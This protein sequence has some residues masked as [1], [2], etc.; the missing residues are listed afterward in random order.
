MSPCR[1]RFL[2]AWFGLAA[3]SGCA[4]TL[5][6][7][8]AGDPWQTTDA[9]RWS[10]A[11]TTGAGSLYDVD[12]KVGVVDSNFGAPASIGGDIEGKL[13]LG[14][15]AEVFA[16]KDWMVFLGTEYRLYDPKLDDE[17]V[18]F[19]T[20]Q[21]FELFLGTRWY[22]P[23]RFLANRRLRVFLQ[24]K[25]AWIPRVDFDLETRLPFSDPLNDA[26][27]VA[28]FEGS[29]YWSL[30]FGGGASYRLADAWTLSLS[31][32]YEWAL[33]SSKGRST[34]DLVQATGNTFVDDLL[35][36]LQYD[37]EVEPY[38]L[39]GFLSLSYSL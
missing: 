1:S 13:G 10:V 29:D 36:G 34:A 25:L 14:V 31:L 32:Y 39:I 12:A 8:E 18:Q 23:W 24:G 38:G 15:Q 19:D 7:D 16:A 21:Q 9:G 2:A 3:L 27:L 33:S 26:L 5:T 35:D 30:G 20:G 37:V 4:T 17:L 11:A 28:P 6:T 22:L